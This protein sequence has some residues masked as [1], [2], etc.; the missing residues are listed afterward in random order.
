MLKFLS[1]TDI[2][3]CTGRNK[4]KKLETLSID[5]KASSS[6]SNGSYD[7]DDDVEDMKKEKSLQYWRV[8]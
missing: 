6:K 3:C 2:L 4:S 5:T 1:F 8:R 7:S